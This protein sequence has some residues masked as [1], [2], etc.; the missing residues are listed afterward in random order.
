MTTLP[1]VLTGRDIP[2]PEL[3]SMRLDGEVYPLADGW[4]AI[5][6]V[7]GPNH[8]AAAA[9]GD[10]SPR[11]IAELGTASWVWGATPVLPRI[12]EF[13]VDLDARARL[14]YHPLVRVRELMLEPG[15][16]VD[17]GAATVTSPLR[18]AVDLARFRDTLAEVER[19]SIVELA[20]L[21]GFGVEECREILER[22]RNLPEKKRAIQRLAELLE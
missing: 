14:R 19:A 21:G 10:R 22:R 13:C 4:C 11:F 5:D 6:E 12:T 17:L 1:F 20:R 9:L 18:T 16:W 3:V 15:D 8:R 2:I 7:E